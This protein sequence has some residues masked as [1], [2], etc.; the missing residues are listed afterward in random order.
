[1]A[2][3]TK[4]PII[5][6]VQCVCARFFCNQSVHEQEG[7]SVFNSYE[8]I[9]FLLTDAACS[10]HYQGWGRANSTVVQAGR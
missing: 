3:P 6:E 5:P 4:L 9:Y 10:I 1:M 7:G 8:S 2:R